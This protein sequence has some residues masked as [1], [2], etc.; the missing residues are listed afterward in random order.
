MTR[1]LVEW[2]FGRH[3]IGFDQIFKNIQHSSQTSTYPPYNIWQVDKHTYRIE[4]A[5]AGFTQEDLEITH[6]KNHL[7]IV[8]EVTL[9]VDSSAVEVHKG[10][11]EKRFDRSFTMSDHMQVKSATMKNGMLVIICHEVI[12]AES[13]SKI[14]K[15]A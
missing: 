11:S 7:S 8:G 9:Q 10:I 15:V 3:A 12:P 14:I 6:H 1:N 13:K 2:P 4:V 5:L